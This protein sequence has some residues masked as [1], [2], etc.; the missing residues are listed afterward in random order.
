MRRT[1]AITREW[2]VRRTT[3]LMSAARG[4]DQTGVINI[5]TDTEFAARDGLTAPV[6]DGM[7]TGNWMSSMLINYYR[8]RYLESGAFDVKF[9]RPTY[10][11]DVTRQNSKNCSQL[12]MTSSSS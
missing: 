10:E 3:S 4:I 9:I 8:L 12:R 7:V 11:N 6:S 2:M 1:A 5:H